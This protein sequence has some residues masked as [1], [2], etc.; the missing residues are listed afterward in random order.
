MQVR[1]LLDSGSAVSFVSERVAESLRLCRFSQNV[2][3]C[4]VP[5]EGSHHSL[6]SFKIAP[7]HNPK[8]QLTVNAVVVPHVTSELPTKH[9]PLNQEWEHVKGLKLAN[10]DF[11]KP[12]KVDLL[13][14]VETFVDIIRHGR[15]RGRRGSPTAIE[16]CFGWVLAGSTNIP[17]AAPLPS[18]HVSA[19]AFDALDSRDSEERFMVPLPKKPT[20]M[21]LG[22]SR[23]QAVRRFL[24]FERMMHSKGQWIK[25]SM[26]I[27]KTSMPSL[28]PKQI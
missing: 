12:G 8:W 10:P 27:L 23:A 19:L 14:G 1:A 16:T 11:G 22:E 24:S 4:G 18:H 9:V 21:E 3:I 6:S 15:R 20:S 13:L 25:L 17:G 28:F 2:Q 5:L 7:V 26:S